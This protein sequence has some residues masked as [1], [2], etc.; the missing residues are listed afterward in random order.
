MQFTLSKPMNK[1]M[2]SNEHLLHSPIES[3]D[4]EVNHRNL[5]PNKQTTKTVLNLT[6]PLLTLLK[7][8]I[9]KP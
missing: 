4:L 5:E 1:E 6:K 3:S 7:N 8:P 9:R 2:N